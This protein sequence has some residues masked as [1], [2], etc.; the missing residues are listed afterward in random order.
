MTVHKVSSNAGLQDA[1][2]SARG[3]DEIELS[4]GS[5][6]LSMRNVSYSSDVTITGS[7]ARFD[8]ID[9]VKVSNLTFDGVDMVAKGSGKSFAF[10]DTSNV[11]I[12]DADIE[13]S[14]GGHGLWLAQGDDFTL[15]NSTIDGFNVGIYALGVT[16]LDIRGN[17]VSNISTD[18]MILGKIHDASIAN[19]DI[20]LNTGNGTKHT[21]GI[22]LWNTGS[23]DPASNVSITGN[24]IV[25]NNTAS[26]G[27]YAGNGNGNGN[28]STHF[29]D[30]EIRDNTI[31]SAQ[32]SGIAVGETSG[33][34]IVGNTVLQDTDFRSNSEIRIPL[35]RVASDSRDVTITGNVT[36]E[37]PA[38]SGN[39]WQE[40]DTPGAWNVSN[41]KIV[42]IGTTTKGAPSASDKSEAPSKT[43]PVAPDTGGDSDGGSSGG[44]NGKADSIR[45]DGDDVSR[46]PSVID[47]FDFGEKDKIV[48]IDYAKGTFKGKVGGNKLDVSSDGTYAKIDSLADLQELESR[49]SAVDILR[50]SNDTLIIEVAQKGEPDHLIHLAGY[51]DDY[52]G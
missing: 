14:G 13:G 1:L 2:R 51:A 8:E 9:L 38:A 6:S 40:L 41:N 48:L 3:G 36:H 21:D 29:K 10:N 47:S 45:F 32:L 34:D 25:T 27:I 5:Y 44:G 28:S 17:E 49:S 19:N 37:T 39:N 30:I 52:F 18:G 15:E 50:G 43:P 20:S 16:G 23:N 11:T 31:V 35:I 46:S 12:R 7:G 4:G 22:Q 33:L 42:A 26:H 24:Y